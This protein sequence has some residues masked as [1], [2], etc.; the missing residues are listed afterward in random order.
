[1][2]TQ[3]QSI[4]NNPIWNQIW[5][6]RTRKLK[7]VMKSVKTK[8]NIIDF[9]LIGDILKFMRQKQFDGLRGND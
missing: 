1:M 7:Y 8:E 6:L 5:K 4:R 9:L 2:E 3:K